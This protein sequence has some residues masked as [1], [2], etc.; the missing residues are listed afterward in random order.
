MTAADFTGTYFG[1]ANG[2]GTV[3]VATTTQGADAIV[4]GTQSTFTVDF[5]AAATA[6]FAAGTFVFDGTTVNYAQGDGSL[7]L[8]NKLGAATYADWNV[9]VTGDVVTFTAKAPGAT[10][11]AGRHGVQG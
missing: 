3:T 5:D 6:A 7:T 10:A 1:A 11:T 4:V 8:A 2:N 9:S